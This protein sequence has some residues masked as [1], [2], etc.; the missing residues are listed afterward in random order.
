MVKYILMP[1]EAIQKIR[2]GDKFFVDG[3]FNPNAARIITAAHDAYF[4][5]DDNNMPHWTV[6]AEGGA[7][8]M[9]MEKSASRFKF[10]DTA[11]NF[12]CI[13]F[14]KMENWHIGR[15][16]ESLVFTKKGR[17]IMRKIKR[18]KGYAEKR[19]Q[20]HIHLHKVF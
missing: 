7:D 16:K 8:A 15:D 20:K 13:F 11:R 4:W 14:V 17:K 1:E 5:V 19:P 9:D 10:F 6:D 18:K 2:K 12:G 3:E